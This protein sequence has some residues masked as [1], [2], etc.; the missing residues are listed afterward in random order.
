M[1]GL[2]LQYSWCKEPT[3]WKR[4]WCWERL[5]AVEDEMVGWHHQFNG[6]EFEQA[7]GVGDG[8]GGLVCCSPWVSKSWTWL[9]DWTEL[10]EWEYKFR[11]GKRIESVGEILEKSE[12]LLAAL[13]PQSHQHPYQS[14]SQWPG[15]G[16]LTHTRCAEKQWQAARVMRKGLCN[17]ISHWA[18]TCLLSKVEM[19]A[20]TGTQF[21][22][23]WGA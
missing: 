4:P 19:A 6:H 16:R 14:W 12:Y 22:T 10:T 20:C 15:A 23:P 8:Q 7:P 1:L 11:F 17:F 2:K 13:R 3:L 5:G 21:G 18:L 9:S